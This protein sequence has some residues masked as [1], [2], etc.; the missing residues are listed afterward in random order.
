M[1][2]GMLT[3]G[4]LTFA[5]PWLLAALVSLPI[6]WWL[7]RL[8]PPSPRQISFP[9]IRLL[10]LLR[11]KEETP[12]RTPWW[13]ILLRLIIAALVIAGLAQPLWNANFGFPRSGPVM[14]VLDDGWAAA[15]GWDERK[16][17]AH[18]LIDRAERNGRDVILATTA[19]QPNGPAVALTPVPAPNAATQL[20]VLAPSPWP[21]DRAAAA[22]LYDKADLPDNLNIFWL[23]DGIGS[24]RAAIDSAFADALRKH[25]G[26][27]VMGMQVELPMMLQTTERDADGLWVRVLRTQVGVAQ[28]VGLRALDREGRTLGISEGRFRPNDPMAR[29]K[30]DLPIELANRT[31]RII[32]EDGA[33]AGAITLLDDGGGRK[34]IGLVSDNPALSRQPMLGEI[35]FIERALAPNHEVRVDKLATLLKQELAV[36]VISDTTPLSDP[37]RAELRKWIERGGMMVRFAGERLAGAP[38]DN[39]LP[40]RI[41]PG[42]RTLG[43]ALSWT[44]P[45]HLAAF[46]TSSPFAGLELPKDVEINRQVLAEPDIDLGNKTWARLTDGTPLVTGER[47]GKGFM[48]LFHV[49]GTADWSNL[50]ISGLFVEML[51]RLVQT[52]SGVV[53]NADQNR[54]LA[55][56]L[57]VNAFGQL[58]PAFPTAT[59]IVAKELPNTKASPRH[60]PGFYGPEGQRRALNLASAQATFSR[61][62]VPARP[63]AADKTI[64]IAPPLFLLAFLLLIADMLIALALRGLMR[65]RTQLA[66]TA[67]IAF[68]LLMV[69]Q[70]SDAQQ[71]PDQ[72]VLAATETTHLGYV[73][74]GVA[75][76]D[77]TSRAGLYGL[78]QTLLRRTS[79]DVGD[80]VAVDVEADELSFYPFLYWP[81]TAGQ[82]TP[83]PQAIEKLN[84]YLAVGGMVFFD[85][86]D[87][88]LIGMSSG[89]LGP[90]AQRL[91]ELTAG[92]DVPR[93]MPIPPDH[94]LTRSFYL[95]R[96][97]PGRWIGGTL[98]VEVPR[99]R[100]NDGVSGVI[101]GSNDY[102]AAWATDDLGQ[103]I[104][105]VTPGGERQREMASRL[106]VNVVMYALTGN[107]KSDQVHVQTILERLGQ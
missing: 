79:V 85:T 56:A 64:E 49:G 26:L 29:V 71:L 73:R 30:V 87:Q 17:A 19:P 20:E 62:T 14:I 69:P 44:E 32:L 68:A 67:S 99:G 39:L 52:A 37:E 1:L 16:E 94:V 70:P 4:S 95:L 61:L 76:V 34:P 89:D 28:P 98:W 38:D 74:T 35:Y 93:L 22:T 3:L 31:S 92:L 81:I 66:A 105:P 15:H 21:T 24:T 86:A 23:T 41:R 12:H 57:S 42:D 55:P 7:L 96:D 11:P 40:V 100:V 63:L 82:R 36:V 51:D 46:P 80:P 43:G 5:A 75:Q 65:R 10:F 72:D 78:T 47:V 8:T 13:L 84:R 77:A 106:G 58:G 102:A 53:A 27:E 25:G 91:M 103:P 33:T 50:P 60:P 2:S 107:Y 18:A 104:F 97:F 48:V 54:P 45:A 83:S 101:V 90:G 9:A 59:A 6:L 88:N